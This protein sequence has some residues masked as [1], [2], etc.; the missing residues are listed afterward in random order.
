MQN[1]LERH[2]NLVRL[3][4]S[5]SNT[6]AI[7]EYVNKKHAENCIKHLSYYELDGEPLY[8]EFAPEGLVSETKDKKNI[9]K[10]NEEE[11]PKDIINI[12]ES[13]DENEEEKKDEG[14]NLVENQGKILFVK[15][16][17]FS[18]NEKQLKKFFEKKDYIV[19]K[20]EI[21]K[22]LKEGKNVSSKAKMSRVG[23]ASLN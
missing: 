9:D 21:A 13:E 5:P 15:N 20:V 22:H 7:C 23:L 4:L 2:G 10:N 8:L 12:N 6:L 17:D 1:L 18:T 11:K 19:K 16:L 3:L 14:I